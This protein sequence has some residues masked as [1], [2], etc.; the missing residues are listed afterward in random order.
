MAESKTKELQDQV[1]KLV[2]VLENVSGGEKAQLKRAM[3]KS[4]DDCQEL[5]SFLFDGLNDEILN[6]DKALDSILKT[7][8]VYAWHGNP[9]KEGF[10]SIGTALG[11][12]PSSEEANKRLDK[13][14]KQSENVDELVHH[15]IKLLQIYKDLPI[16]YR[17]LT[18]DIYSMHFGDSF[19]QVKFRWMKD[20]LKTKV[21]DT[22]NEKGQN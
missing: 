20:F 21:K 4:L 18:K 17:I 1:S 12:L 7:L 11:K 14:F 16:D 10:A 3:D 2:A 19:N 5:W 13:L 8:T 9:Q 6:D 15:L 22:N